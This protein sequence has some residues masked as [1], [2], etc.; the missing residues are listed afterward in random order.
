MV[1]CVVCKRKESNQEHHLLY[2]P[3]ELKIP[4]CDECH[5]LIHGKGTGPPRMPEEVKFAVKGIRGIPTDLWK[6][7]K[8]RCALEGISMGEYVSKALAAYLLM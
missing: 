8:M 5:V 3:F 6:I 2:E 7:T 4:I 1:L